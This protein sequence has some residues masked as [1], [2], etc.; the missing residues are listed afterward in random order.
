MSICLF[1]SPETVGKSVD[2]SVQA[3]ACRLPR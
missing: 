1:L 3:M 2:K